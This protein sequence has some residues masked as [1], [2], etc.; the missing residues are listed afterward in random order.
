MMISDAMLKKLNEQVTHEFFASHVYLAMACMFDDKALKLLAKHF[1][2]QSEEEREHALKLIDYIITQ[3][4]VVTLE[5]ID[6]PPTEWQTVHAA[7]EQAV[8]HEIKVTKLI[9]SLCELAESEKDYATRTFL[10]WFVDEQVEEV[11][12]MQHLADVAKMCGNS[13][14]NLEAYMIHHMGD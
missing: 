14:I 12:S 7:I 10:N 3:G 1:R 4:G 9:D 6:K 8:E 2:K 11:D 13:L 5:Q